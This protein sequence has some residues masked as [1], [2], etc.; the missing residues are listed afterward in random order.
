M[1]RTTDAEVSTGGGSRGLR[2]RN[3]GDRTAAA[4]GTRR[5]L[6]RLW[7]DRRLAAVAALALP[8]LWGVIAGWWTPR[9]PLTTLEVLVAMFAGL[10][11]G[12]SSGIALGSRWA[13]LVAPVA[14]VVALELARVGTV[15]P[16]VDAPRFS[17]YGL[18]AFAVGRGYHGLVALAPMVLGAALGAGAARR[19]RS[20]WSDSSE[21]RHASSRARRVI[22]AMSAMLLVVLA[23]FVARPASTDQIPGPDGEPLAGSIAE[24]TTV[25]HGGHDLGL[26]IRGSSV[27]NPVVLFLAGGPGGSERGAMRNHLEALEETFTVATWDQRGT[28]TSYTELDP[29][30]T[31]TLD[32][33]VADTIAVT[34]YLRERFGQDQ[35]HLLG[36][37]WGSTLGVLAAQEAPELY[38][39][40]I[41]T[42]Q[43]VSQLETD[44][45]F[46]EDTLA[47]AE[48]EGNTGLADRLRSIGPPPYDDMLDYETALSY[49]H[50]VYPYDHSPNSEGQGGFSENFIVPEY[51]LTDQVHLL[52]SFMDTFSV[53]YPQLQDIDFRE[54]ATELEVPV[55]F[56]QGAHEADGRA[57][58]FAEWFEQ[59]EAPRKDL[60]VLDTSGHRPLFEQPDEFVAHMNDV[61]LPH[62]TDGDA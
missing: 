32:S 58:P 25:E 16:T 13:M 59:L 43:M 29:T 18:L 11:V 22:A 51:T 34:N 49:E 54:T 14:F 35:I 31:L 52:G 41:G 46:Y 27:D 40:L 5:L 23:V 38:R 17:T 19:L 8:V 55:F 30:E 7:A 33:Y 37:S 6:E 1:T 3:H 62:T 44:T 4:A 36:Q 48:E 2:L 57:E 12:L 47:W 50:Q 24:L 61:V 42:G 56:V 15:G 10:L 26:M 39:A 53:L 20:S 28:G 9:G 60:V 45:L 21:Q